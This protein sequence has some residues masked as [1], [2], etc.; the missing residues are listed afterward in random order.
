MPDF[1]G[2]VLSD[3]LRR[4]VISSG[5]LTS[6]GGALSAC[7]DEFGWISRNALNQISVR[8]LSAPFRHSLLFL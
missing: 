7:F 5:H 2:L 3:I 4:F 1:S 8:S 6:F